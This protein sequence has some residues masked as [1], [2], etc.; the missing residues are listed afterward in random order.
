MR[1]F[2][3]GYGIRTNAWLESNLLGTLNSNPCPWEP[4]HPSFTSIHFQPNWEDMLC[5][6]HYWQNSWLPHAITRGQHEYQSDI[7]SY[8]VVVVVVVVVVLVYWLMRIFWCWCVNVLLSLDVVVESWN[9]LLVVPVILLW[10]QASFHDELWHHF[11][12]FSSL[13]TPFLPNQ[14]YTRLEV[15]ECLTGN[16][17][18]IPTHFWIVITGCV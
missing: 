17:E 16:W 9:V 1:Y 18:L 12:F 7:G 10:I 13:F 14:C 4:L 2:D 8:I 3:N 5:N 11:F 15:W 6:V